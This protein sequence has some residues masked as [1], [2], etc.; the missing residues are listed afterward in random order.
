MSYLVKLPPSFLT[1]R[2]IQ[3]VLNVAVLVTDA[4]AIFYLSNDNVISYGPTAWGI[5]TVSA[6]LQLVMLKLTRKDLLYL[7]RHW[8]QHTY[9]QD[10][11][12]GTAVCYPTGPGTPSTREMVR[13]VG[14]SCR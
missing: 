4:L 2:Y 9:R 3:L 1:L 8:V 6:A 12:R 5:W 10:K 13:A 7:H 14:L 11:W